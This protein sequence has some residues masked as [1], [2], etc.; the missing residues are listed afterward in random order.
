MKEVQQELNMALILEN[1]FGITSSI[2]YV[3]SF[4][5]EIQT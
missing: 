3:F 2:P 5:L 4:F 1:T